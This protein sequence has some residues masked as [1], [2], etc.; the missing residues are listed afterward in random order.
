V[1]QQMHV[2]RQLLGESAGGNSL[3]DDSLPDM[4]LP[5]ISV[6]DSPLPD[7]QHPGAHP[8]DLVGKQQIS[9]HIAQQVMVV[10]FREGSGSCLVH[11]LCSIL[12]I[13]CIDHYTY[14]KVFGLLRVNFDYVFCIGWSV[15][16]VLQDSAHASFWQHLLYNDPPCDG[17]EAQ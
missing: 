2:D 8:D 14:S 17:V 7:V 11:L 16:T 1:D 5:V 15:F 10:A 9:P 3:P 12:L 13:S 4:P 6:P